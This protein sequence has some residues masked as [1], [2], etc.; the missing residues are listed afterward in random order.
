MGRCPENICFHQIN[1][2][3]SSLMPSIPHYPAYSCAY[4]HLLPPTKYYT[5]YYPLHTI[6]SVPH[7][8][9]S[10]NTTTWALI[11]T[12]GVD[13]S[14]HFNFTE[15]THYDAHLT[16][17]WLRPRI[18]LTWSNACLQTRLRFPFLRPDTFQSVSMR[19]K[20]F[21]M[22][23]RGPRECICVADPP[24][25]PRA[26]LPPRAY[27]RCRGWQQASFFSNTNTK[28]NIN[29]NTHIKYQYKYT[30]Q[31][32]IQIQRPLLHDIVKGCQWHLSTK[33]HTE[34]FWTYFTNISYHKMCY[35]PTH[36]QELS[37]LICLESEPIS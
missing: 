24:A 12:R 3:Y 2:L 15:A 6:V 10:M 32:S 21:W 4:Y 20:F 34:V 29:T 16:L 18:M 13:T 26:S 27:K 33:F 25:R 36:A 17:F 31:I 22:H 7:A 37:T 23:L 14:D 8:A 35:F 9:A 1:R 5:A 30:N 11:T 19:G 28:S